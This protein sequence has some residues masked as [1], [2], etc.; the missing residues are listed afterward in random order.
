MTEAAKKTGVEEFRLLDFFE[1]NGASRGA[2]D[3]FLMGRS[4]RNERLADF[5]AILRLFSEADGLA[6][7]R[8]ALVLPPG[9][10]IA[11]E[12]VAIRAAFAASLSGLLKRGLEPDEVDN[13]F[14][15]VSVLPAATLQGADLGALVRAAEPKTVF[16]IGDAALYRADGVEVPSYR[17]SLQEDFWSPHLHAVAG[18]LH[19]ASEASKSYVVLDAGEEMPERA[20]NR[21]LLCSIDGA[22]TNAER[23]GPSRSELARQYEGW[24]RSVERGQLDP[25]LREIGGL[26]V[27]D[28]RKTILK[29]QMFKFA[30]AFEAARTVL[31][32]GR[33]QLHGLEPDVSLQVAVLAE[34]VDADEV[35]SVLLKEAIPGLRSRE[36]L[37]AG[38]ELADRLGDRLAVAAAETA[39]SVSFPASDALLVHRA[40][41]LVRERRFLEAAEM[42]RQVGPQ[43]NESAEFYEMLA[44]ALSYATLDD[45]PDA[46]KSVARRFP[47]RRASALRFFA[48]DLELRGHRAAGIALLVDDDVPP[49]SPPERLS[50]RTALSMVERGRLMLD[51]TIDDE[52]VQGTLSIAVRYLAFHPADADMRVNVVRIVSPEVL[53]S[54]GLP[55]VA[56]LVLEIAGVGDSIRA[57]RRVDDRAQACP[58]ERLTEIMRRGFDAMAQGGAV[59]GHFAFPPEALSDPPAA[60][61]RG[62]AEMIEHTGERAMDDGD[63]RAIEA[64]VLMATAI[65]PLGDEPDEDLVVMRLAA[66]RLAFGG[67]VQHARDLAEQ[68]LRMAGESPHRRRLAWFAFADVYARTGNLT[69]ALVAVAC[70]M[71]ADAEATW[72][73]I[74]YESLLL[75]RLFRDLGLLPLARPLLQPAR[76]A[77]REMGASDRYADR[78]ETVELQLDHLEL[79]GAPQ[80]A[81]E[82]LKEIATRAAT[83]LV[84]VL[85]IGDEPAPATIL[86]ANIQR[87]ADDLNVELP[88][89]VK[90]TL[91]RAL[92]QAAGGV[93]ALLEV[94]GSENPT[95]GHV[96]ALAARLQA[97][98]FAEDA[99]YDVRTLVVAA[100]RLLAA[101]EVIEPATTI[102]AIE[103]MSDQ[104]VKLPAGSTP[105]R[106]LD[107]PDAPA[108]AAKAISEEG[109]PVVGLGLAER[110]L[111]RIVATGGNLGPAILESR[112]V[113]SSARLGEWRRTYP[114]AY[115]DAKAV[116]NEFYSSTDGIGVSDLPERAVVVASI[117]LQGFPV[118]LLR[119]GQH[120][121]GRDRRLAAAPSLSWLLASRRRPFRGDGRIAAWI[122]DAEPEEGLPTLAILSDRLRDTFERH[123]VALSNGTEPPSGLEGADLVVVAAH[124]GLAEDKRYFRVVTDDV[125]LALA[126]STVSGALAGVG[127]VVLLVCSGGRLDQHPGASTTVGL[128]K[129]LLDNG[130]RAVVAPPWPLQ[131]NVPPRWL[132]AFLR[133]WSSGAP[134]IDACFDANVVVR[135]ELGDD[136][137]TDLAMAV[138]GDPLIRT[139]GDL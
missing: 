123:E 138:Y 40:K 73:Q 48:Q 58:P 19:Q 78:L 109:L 87:T 107:D 54:M 16:V 29:A 115:K 47:S 90:D 97:P 106:L 43:E 132:P 10:D 12:I 44:G 130:C 83:N 53:G 125:D 139:S 128:A 101:E 124:G 52:A 24:Q 113:F 112:D 91:T 60:V 76:R 68:A 35:A 6:F 133:S 57:D 129:R 32:A 63:V 5:A 15:N 131:T 100:R 7:A 37:G 22:V 110:G 105:D 13:A 51:R 79:S 27:E 93:R 74:W 59:M 98:R 137:A 82:A 21:R 62:F 8:I 11:S 99:G 46:L 85:E 119:V 114:Y 75:L 111:F 66:G 95:I 92:S 39:L 50:V 17:P 84:R 120:L 77:L 65:A 72:D 135:A 102:Y 61:V 70:T 4:G 96:A 56:K 23:E 116:D 108:K 49:G 34:S 104:A 118:D 3:L 64:C 121:A 88:A 67:R 136:P 127:V 117:D 38:L 31:E 81:P 9:S 122:P 26:D 80:P 41:A 134:V 71:T 2:A 45:A 94:V 18:L 33:E 14:R 36:F 25:V 86:L 30:G 89:A 42:F 55:T 1:R 69:E 28:R 103:A 20:E 126:S